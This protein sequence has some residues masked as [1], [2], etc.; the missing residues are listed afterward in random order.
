MKWWWREHRKLQC[1]YFPVSL[2]HPVNPLIPAESLW[3]E[4][5]FQVREIW[6]PVPTYPHRSSQDFQTSASGY[7]SSPLRPYN[8]RPCLYQVDFL[9]NYN[10]PNDIIGGHKNIDWTLTDS[11]KL[12]QLTPS[13]LTLICFGLPRK[14]PESWQFHILA[15]NVAIITFEWLTWQPLPCPCSWNLSDD[16][17]PLHGVIF[18][19]GSPTHRQ[20][21][22]VSS[23]LSMQRLS[24][25]RADFPDSAFGSA[26]HA[27][28]E[29]HS[30]DCLWHPP[31]PM[32]VAALMLLLYGGFLGLSQP[33]RDIPLYWLWAEWQLCEATDGLVSCVLGKEAE[34]ARWGHRCLEKLPPCVRVF[35][36]PPPPTVPMA[37][38]CQREL[39]SSQMEEM[40]T[41]R[42]R[43]R[44][45]TVGQIGQ[46]V[47]GRTEKRAG[48]FWGPGVG[49]LDGITSFAS[50][51]NPRFWH[52]VLSFANKKTRL[53]PSGH[54]PVDSTPDFLGTK[55]ERLSP[56]H[57]IR[58][59]RCQGLS[60][61]HER[62]QGR[63]GEETQVVKRPKQDPT[64]RF[65]TPWANQKLS[66]VSILPQ[67]GGR[68]R[69]SLK[70]L[71]G[72]WVTPPL[73]SWVLPPVTSSLLHLSWRSS[74]HSPFT[75]TSV[76]RTSH[77]RASNHSWDPAFLLLK[78]LRW[79]PGLSELKPEYLQRPI[80]FQ[81]SSP[82]WDAA[83]QIPSTCHAESTHC[84][85][86]A[87]G[88]ANEAE[89][90]CRSACGG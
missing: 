60:K 34:G 74:G 68:P 48:W 36:S 3:E 47:H 12:F 82:L 58:P 19:P 66:T 1:N 49:G 27:L 61:R 57:W 18:L 14:A 70:S 31:R 22:R 9:C 67:A 5:S 80:P 79:L 4:T 15:L 53:I 54:R 50:Q 26:T 41:I 35:Q 28:A 76:T 32:T 40:P 59:P 39:P 63:A 25:Q 2:R 89:V 8:K 23:S 83:Y 44:C 16:A 30:R 73:S 29:G 71:V 33:L 21:S 51:T 7:L 45:S 17:S 62:V 75:L 46:A 88:R 65:R 86:S 52:C 84:H 43:Q 87:R 24:H 38:S 64:G 37:S 13:C 69:K 55:N 6:V 56:G 20:L 10:E 81:A 78:T 11:G 72:K 77:R 42:S 85:M 90:P